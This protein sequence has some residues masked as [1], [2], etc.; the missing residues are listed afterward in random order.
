MCEIPTKW[1][2]TPEWISE[3]DKKRLIA[4]V[5]ELTIKCINE[6]HIHKF[7]RKVYKQ[8]KGGATSLRHTGIL[9]NILMNQWQNK[10]KILMKETWSKFI[11]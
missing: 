10:M 7:N 1:E 5:L 6:N 11:V 8:N 2:T 4:K 3:N 9:A